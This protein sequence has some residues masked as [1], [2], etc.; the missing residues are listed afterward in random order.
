[1]PPKKA[2]APSKKTEQKKKEKVIEDKTFGL[3]NKKG[4]KAQKFIAQVEKQVKQGGNPDCR[5]QEQQRLEEKK[6]KE[7][8]KKESDEINNLF[9]PVQTQKVESGV[10]PKS[11]FCAFFKQG[12]CKKGDKCK[13]SHDP[14]VEKKAVKRNIYEEEKDEEDNME[15]WDED[16]LAEVVSK[17]HGAEKGNTTDIVC[18]YFLEAVE[19]NKYGWFW[20]CPEKA[21]NNSCKYKH[22]LPKGF[23]LKKDKKRMEREKEE[24]SIEDLIEKERAALSTGTL[25]KVTL[26]TFVAWKKKKLKE[27]A[28][29]EKKAKDKKK[30]N[31]KSGNTSGLSGREMFQF[32]PSIVG[33]VNTDEDEEGG[34]FDLNMRDQEEDDGVKVHEI[35]FDAYGIMDDGVD[36]STDVQLARARAEAGGAAGG[37]A[38][39]STNGA[40]AATVIDEDL[41]DD[42]D[43]EELEEN[44]DKLD[45]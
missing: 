35:K 14:N 32:N 27:K 12:L 44:L 19:N 30:D 24:I 36:D 13:F 45:L 40:A 4:G 41:F 11:I 28:D 1:M 39:P 25:T 34:E 2:N 31:M 15:D 21:K 10:D 23:V 26:E 18:K 5:K 37:A 22:A 17:K 42:E 7:L 29:A 20:E 16:K 6:K 43:L 33:Q 3:K 9:K 8:A 38:G